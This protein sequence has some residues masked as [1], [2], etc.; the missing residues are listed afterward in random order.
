MDAIIISS[1]KLIV[2]AELEKIKINLK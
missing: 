1:A 2:L